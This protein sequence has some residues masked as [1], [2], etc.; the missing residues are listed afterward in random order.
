MYATLVYATLVYAMLVYATC[1]WLRT[2]VPFPKLMDING[3]FVCSLPSLDKASFLKA[4]GEG[5]RDW[6][7]DRLEGK[8]GHPLSEADKNWLDPSTSAGLDHIFLDR[9]SS[10]YKDAISFVLKGDSNLGL[11]KMDQSWSLSGFGKWAHL[12]PGFCMRLS[13]AVRDVLS[14]AGF[15]CFV[16]GPS[17]LI[18]KP[19]SG[20]ALAAHHDQLA[21]QELLLALREHM[22][23]SDVSTTAWV[24][25][26]R[27]QCLVHIAGRR[28]DGFTY[29]IG[30]MTPAR[31]LICME[32]F[33]DGRV[34]DVSP[35]FFD[36]KEGPHFLKW[37][38]ALPQ[39]NAF[40]AHLNEPPLRV[41][42]MV[43]LSS[44]GDDPFVIVWPVGYP[45][46]SA[47]NKT[48]AVSATVCLSFEPPTD[49]RFLKR[50]RCMADLQSE[51]EARREAAEAWMTNDKVPYEEGRTHKKPHLAARWIRPGGFYSSL[52]PTHADVDMLAA[53]T[54]DN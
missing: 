46:G 18:V 34:R 19:P 36:R 14:E 2:C 13:A 40:L 16:K 42:P 12:N 41:M 29:M 15:R 21:P 53:A 48:L 10:P 44:A 37:Q 28:T 25:K 50:A 33:A 8:L 22:K 45:H 6:F 30:P 49:R 24:K 32:A 9:K 39:L 54:R 23:D 5:Q 27:F 11:A 1:V 7:H 31:L 35:E 26:Q 51:D 43:P 20:V 17:H 4:L 3:F 38:S 52:A 47:K